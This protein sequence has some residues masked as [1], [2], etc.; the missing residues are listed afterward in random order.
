MRPNPRSFAVGDAEPVELAWRPRL[1]LQATERRVL[2]WG[3]G[4]GPGPLAA[5]EFV[6]IF[7]SNRSGMLLLQTHK[8]MTSSHHHFI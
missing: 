6:D 1:R 3:G 8:V 7:S 4:G 5:Y 2:P